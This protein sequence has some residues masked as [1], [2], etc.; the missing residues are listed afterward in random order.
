MPRT[1]I[2]GDLHGCTGELEE[3][4]DQVRFVAGADRLVMVGDLVARGPD[5]HGALA[6]VRR[7]GALA[8]RGN[9]EE[10]LLT[11]RRRHEP[12]GPDHA[13]LAEALS[14][15]EWAQIEALPLWLDLPEHGVRVV[16]GGVVPGQAIEE[17]EPA[18]LLKMR[19]LDERGR[20]SSGA[21]DGDLWGARY[22]GPPHVVFGH[23][24]RSEPQLHAWAT[25]L[26]TGCVYGGKLTALVL[27]DGES[28]PRG[29]RVAALLHGVPAVRR[30]YGTAGAKGAPL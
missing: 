14:D 13:H 10:R 27:A 11:W 8:V 15:E 21:D 30:Y 28:V 2:V 18:A 19:T 20:W 24:A 22:V 6:L 29:S 1:I 7:L 17:T 26:D 12:L 25:G 4:L 3:L 16:H 9:H 23:N 5:S